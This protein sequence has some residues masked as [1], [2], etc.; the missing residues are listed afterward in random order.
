M[1]EPTT[2]SFTVL[3]TRTS[4]GIA[5]ARNTAANMHGYTTHLFA[6]HLAFTGMEP[7]SDLDP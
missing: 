5:K 2:K 3:E 4:P 6:H 7:S 1:P